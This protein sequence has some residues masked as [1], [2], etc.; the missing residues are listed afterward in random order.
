MS[1]SHKP[2]PADEKDGFFNRLINGQIITGAMFTRYGVSIVAILTMLLV[3]ITGV[4]SVR[5]K[6]ENIRKLE[7]RLVVV[8]TESMRVKGLYMSRIRESEMRARLDSLN[9]PLAV[10]QQPPYR[11]SLK[12]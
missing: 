11:L 2:Q 3:Y 12:K 4:F 10:Q 1:Q 8:Q 5:S 6:M 9:L 7:D